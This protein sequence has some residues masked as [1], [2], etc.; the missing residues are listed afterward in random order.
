MPAPSVIIALV[1]DAPVRSVGVVHPD[2]DRRPIS[3]HT[4]QTTEALARRIADLIGGRFVGEAAQGGAYLVPSRTLVAGLNGPAITGEED[5]FGGIVPFPFVATKAITHPLVA[6]D[7]AAPPG[8]QQS[9][10]DGI[11][12]AVPFGFTAFD[13]ESAWIAGMRVLARGPARVK[14]AAADGG[15]DQYVVRAPDELVAAIEA[16][17]GND[18][19]LTGIVIEEN[20]DDTTTLSVGRVL[21]AGC[22]VSYWGRQVTTPDHQGGSAYGGSTL[23]LV[24]G[25]FDALLATALPGPV[26]DAVTQSFRYDEAASRAFPGLIASRR[27][28][29][30]IQGRDSAG[31]SR[32]AVLEQS[33]RLGG[34]SSAEILGVEA[35]LADPALQAVTASSR[36]IYG[37]PGRLPDGAAI[38]FSGDDPQVGLLT[39]YAVIETEPDA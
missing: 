17:A 16:A 32:S 18:L 13:L 35:F 7:A 31:H 12:D 21:I 20:L 6:G 39:K 5:L 4:R 2:V 30:V 3:L 29:D 28:Y 37:E 9:L 19:A 36:E 23:H 34:A 38:I 22:E 15:H 25:G 14:R 8:W 1:D 27:N 24:R 33:W 26:R 11:G 10:T